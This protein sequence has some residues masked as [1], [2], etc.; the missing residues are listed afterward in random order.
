MKY[1]PLAAQVD[2]P[3][4]DER[5]NESDV[6]LLVIHNISLPPEEFGGDGIRGLFTGTLDYSA[7]PFYAQLEGL[8][9][10]A[11]CVIYRDGKIEQ[12]VPFSHRA[13]HAGVSSFQGVSRCND[14]SIGIELE[15]TDNLAYTQVQYDALVELTSFIRKVYPRI[16]LGRIVG[17]NDIAPGRKTDPGVAFNWTYFRQRINHRKSLVSEPTQMNVTAKKSREKL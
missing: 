10:S 6:N 15:G 12:Y 14:Y 2:C 9:V 8:R 17:H 5:P 11:H 7:H 1:Y 13:W 3:F 16:S 4:F